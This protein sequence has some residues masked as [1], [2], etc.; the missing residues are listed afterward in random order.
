[1][2]LFF[3]IEEGTDD[4]TPE[5]V[6]ERMALLKEAMSQR[7]IIAHS[8]PD[9][10]RP[11]SNWG[12]LAVGREFWDNAGPQMRPSTA[13]RFLKS[14]FQYLD[15][16]VAEAVDRA[17]EAKHNNTPVYTLES[18]MRLR[19]KTIG[20]EPSYAVM[21]LALDQLDEAEVTEAATSAPMR[22]LAKIAID[23]IILGNVSFFFFCFLFF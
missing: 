15:S 11:E 22:E 14:F 16:V 10:E 8:G 21:E 18:Y 1:M 7:D 20:A 5:V 23:I 12:G 9:S 2:N 4:E 13:S 3:C 17:A 19:R 6:A